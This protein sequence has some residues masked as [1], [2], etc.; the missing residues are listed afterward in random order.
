MEMKIVI[1]HFLFSPYLSEVESARPTGYL[2][3]VRV[4]RKGKK[5]KVLL[6]I[7]CRVALQCIHFGHVFHARKKETLE[8]KFKSVRKSCKM[9]TEL[10]GPSRVH[11]E[12]FW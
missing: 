1:I 7:C 6:V 2:G 10:L 12:K 3:T 9:N 4:L 8:F 11:C 5:V